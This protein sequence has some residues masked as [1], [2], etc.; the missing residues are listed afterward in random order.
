[1]AIVKPILDVIFSP[2]TNNLPPQLSLIVISILITFLITIAYKYL[3]N[4]QAIKALRDEIKIL[5][6]EIKKNR[7]NKEKVMDLN[8]QLMKKNWPLMR[9]TMWPSLYTLIPVLIL[10]SWLRATYLPAG[11]LFAWGF[12]IP[13]FGIGIGW[14]WTYI[15]TS[16]VTNTLF[17]KL[18]KVS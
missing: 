13:F 4:Q 2:L 14:L 1:M 16:L 12:K 15:L 8:T 11:D 18:L 3:S 17:R 5:Q 6:E 9:H 10:F 7:D